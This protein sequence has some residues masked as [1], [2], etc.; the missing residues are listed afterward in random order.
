MSSISRLPGMDHDHYEFQSIVERPALR[1]PGGCPVAFC[2]LISVEHF[3]WIPPEGAV[4]S[5]PTGLPQG[6]VQP[7]EIR[8]YTQRQYGNR[9]GVFRLMEVLDRHGVR[10]TMAIDA[11][12]A[13]LCPTIVAEAKKRRWEFI[14]HG[15]AVTQMVSS[16]MTDKQEQNYIRE[17]IMGVAAAT[18]EAPIGWLAPEYSE[19]TRTPR[20]LAEAG[21][22]YLCD[23]PNDEQ[24]YFMRAGATNLV[25]L[26]VLLDLDDVIA[27]SVRHV[28]IMRYARLAK[29]AF[30][31]LYEDGRT[32]GRLMVLNIHPWLMGHPFRSKYFDEIITYVVNRKDVWVATGSEIAQ[33]FER[34]RGATTESH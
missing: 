29:E 18:G 30:D 20:L 17:A 9:V 1:W 28:P 33:W 22:R 21:I 23:W 16:S 25:S 8:P 15:V 5:S 26:P 13:A 14:A 3:D 27:H 24:P 6:M 10:A 31:R 7:P 2:L 11:T 19:S 4:F 12:T 32:S 34:Q